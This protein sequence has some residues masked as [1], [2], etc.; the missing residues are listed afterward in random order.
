MSGQSVH[1]KPSPQTTVASSSTSPTTS[2]VRVSA[3]ARRS[4]IHRFFVRGR[5]EYRGWV[6]NLAGGDVRTFEHG[7]VQTTK[8]GR[9]TVSGGTMGARLALVQRR[10]ADRRTDSCMVHH[11]GYAVSGRLHVLMDDGAEIEV[12]PGDAH[13][14]RPGHD[15]WVVGGEP[16]VAIDFSNDMAG[17]AKPSKQSVRLYP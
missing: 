8:V 2:R 10:Q 14:I 15:A 12:G 1:D 17:Y 11:K 5:G 7:K 9:V 13:D 4:R 6:A 16:Y 3:R